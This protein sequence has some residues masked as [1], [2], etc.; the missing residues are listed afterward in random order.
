MRLFTMWA[1]DCRVVTINADNPEEAL[2]ALSALL[3]NVSGMVVRVATDAEALCW[4]V[5]ASEASNVAVARSKHY[6][7]STT[8]RATTQCSSASARPLAV[9]K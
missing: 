9:Y 3:G 6:M 7:R 1:G 5:S 4:N 2:Q 8:K